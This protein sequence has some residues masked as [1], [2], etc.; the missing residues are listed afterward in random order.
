M[1]ILLNRRNLKIHENIACFWKAQRIGNRK[2]NAATSDYFCNSA[3]GS[4]QILKADFPCKRLNARKFLVSL[5]VICSAQPITYVT[6]KFKGTTFSKRLAQVQYVTLS[7]IPT[8]IQI[9]PKISCPTLH[10]A[11]QAQKYLS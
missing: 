8:D 7:Q 9:L 4:K 2:V 3:H 6:C 11:P 5:D 1:L 10:K